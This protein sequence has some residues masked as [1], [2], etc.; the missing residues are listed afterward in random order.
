MKSLQTIQK[1]FGVF[2][3]LS[4]IGMIL[5]FVWVGL[6]A[7][8]LLCG[9]VWFTGGSVYGADQAL[10]QALT[11]TG[12]LTEMIGELLVDM[13]LALTDGVLLVF[14]YRYFKSE[15]ADGTPFTQQGADQ[16][17]RLGI[18]NIVLPLVVAVVCTLVYEV[19]GLSE[20]TVSDW[21]NLDRLTMGIFLILTSFVFRYGA[22]LEQA[23][24]KSLTE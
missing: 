1:A 24:S 14:A 21:S 2:K 16:I 19:T 12:G 18:L 15:L 17:F 20:G 4:K 5:S 23:V 7:L 22:D 13:L 9:I 6:I 8:G 11:E 3:V 10:I